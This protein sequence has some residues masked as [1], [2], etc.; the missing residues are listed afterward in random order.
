MILKIYLRQIPF[1]RMLSNKFL[2]YYFSLVFHSIIFKHSKKV[3]V[4]NER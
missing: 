3:I 4:F 2:I 1:I